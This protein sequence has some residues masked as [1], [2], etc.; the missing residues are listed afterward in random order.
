MVLSCSRAL[1]SH[2]LGYSD[3]VTDNTT[4]QESLLVKEWGL[5]CK[6]NLKAIKGTRRM[7]LLIPISDIMLS[8]SGSR[9][10]KP[11]NFAS[12]VNEQISEAGEHWSLLICDIQASS[13]GVEVQ[14]GHIDSLVI[15][16]NRDVS[17][18]V[19][20]KIHEVSFFVLS[21]VC[22]NFTDMNI[23]VSYRFW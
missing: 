15:S 18:V 10:K 14:F 21:L 2:L 9:K 7:K 12:K 22:T 20:D 5:P 19:A 17:D 3:K 13:S 16:D 4:P 11:L 1:C 23:I 6:S 8:V